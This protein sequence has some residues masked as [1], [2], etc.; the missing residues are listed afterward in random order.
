MNC[1]FW[2]W[3]LQIHACEQSQCESLASQV[4]ATTKLRQSFYSHLQGIV[5]ALSFRTCQVCFHG[6]LQHLHL[7]VRVPK[8]TQDSLGILGDTRGSEKLLVGNVS[9]GNCLQ[10]QGFI[11]AV[12]FIFEALDRLLC[13]LHRR[14]GVSKKLCTHK[15]LQRFL[16]TFWVIQLLPKTD[17]LSGCF[18]SR[19]RLFL[20]NV[21]PGQELQCGSFQVLAPIPLEPHASISCPLSS[22]GWLTHLRFYQDKSDF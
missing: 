11:S 12:P 22:F 15:E 19:R 21:S 20:S 2:V 8:L 3:E 7:A 9:F 13:Y 10:C 16:L 1:S 4:V 18:S 17:C 6:G 5:L 14:T